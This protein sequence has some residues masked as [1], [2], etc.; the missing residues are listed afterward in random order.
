MPA[1]I[2][3][4]KCSVGV[5]SGD[6][7][8]LPDITYSEENYL[9]VL[10]GSC[11]HSEEVIKSIQEGTILELNTYASYLSPIIKDGKL[12]AYGEIIVSDE[13]FGVRISEVL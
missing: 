6:D 8:N 5:S 13:N 12:V 9:S 7:K 2:R 3:N 10:L 4:E 1:S 11:Y